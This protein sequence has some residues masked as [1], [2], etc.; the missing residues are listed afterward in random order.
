M[1]D[2]KVLDCFAPLHVQTDHQG[3]ITHI[4]PALNRLLGDQ[5]VLGQPILSLVKIDRPHQ[6]SHYLD[7]EAL[8]GARLHISMPLLADFTLTGV[9]AKGQSGGVLNLSFGPELV[10]AVDQLSLS[11]QD[12]AATDLA[13]EL[14]Y[15]IEANSA[16]T[17]FS[18][19]L[20]GRIQEAR[21]KAEDLAQKDPLTGLHNRRS[22]DARLARALDNDHSFALL[23]TDLDYFKQVNDTLGHQA[24]DY[25]LCHV[26]D[27]LTRFSRTDDCAARLGGDEFAVIY[28]NMPSPEQALQIYARILAKIRAPLKFEGQDCSI[29]ASAGL[30]FVTPQTDWRAD[31]LIAAVD[32]ALYAAKDHGRSALAMCDQGGANGIRL[33]SGQELA[34]FQT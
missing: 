26:A 19:A 11:A 34:E 32:R 13:L 25:V 27:T 18:N 14:L 4:G 15:L 28:H 30:I 2:P 9:F 8:H 7:L 33:Y 21:K 16:I 31:D 10:Q 20:M 29:S 12:F 3:L 22:F 1:I 6:I 24:G 23:H 5:T 17:S